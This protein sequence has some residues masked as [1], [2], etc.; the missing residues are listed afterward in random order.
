MSCLVPSRARAKFNLSR[1]RSGGSCSLGERLLLV[2]VVPCSRSF[3]FT[4]DLDHTSSTMTKSIR[5]SAQNIRSIIWYFTIFKDLLR[6]I[7]HLKNRNVY[8]HQ[9]VDTIISYDLSKMHHDSTSR[10]KLR[11]VR[12]MCPWFLRK[13]VSTSVSVVSKFSFSCTPI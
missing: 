8:N 10:Q 4:S 3:W 7:L 2:L 13:V 5:S 11:F 1:S 6:L 12:V 9:D